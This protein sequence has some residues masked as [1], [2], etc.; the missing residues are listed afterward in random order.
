M[1]IVIDGWPSLSFLN[2]DLIINSGGPSADLIHCRV[3]RSHC[4]SAAGVV[5]RPISR[6][7]QVYHF[8]YFAKDVEPANSASEAV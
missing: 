4:L 6:I 1:A 8:G 7:D 3:G 2:L 5:G